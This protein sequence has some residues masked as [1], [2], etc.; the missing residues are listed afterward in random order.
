M[1]LK[2]DAATDKGFF[3]LKIENAASGPLHWE[4]GQ[5]L[6]SIRDKTNHGLGLSGIKEITSRYNGTIETNANEA[7]FTLLVIIPIKKAPFL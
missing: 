7:A 3:I 2:L 5:I 6:T 1:Y 4:N